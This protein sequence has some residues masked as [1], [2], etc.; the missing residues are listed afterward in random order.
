MVYYY[1]VDKRGTTKTGLFKTKSGLK[2]NIGFGTGY[3]KGAKILKK[4]TKRGF[5]WQ[6]KVGP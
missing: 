6:A 5:E 4:K 1:A 2:R 3:W